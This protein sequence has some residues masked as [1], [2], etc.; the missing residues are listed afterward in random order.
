M[1]DPREI[2]MDITQWV[3]SVFFFIFSYG[4]IYF[5]VFWNWYNNRRSP[6]ILFFFNNFQNKRLDFQF[7]TNSRSSYLLFIRWPTPPFRPWVLNWSPFLFCIH[8]YSIVDEINRNNIISV[9]VRWW[10]PLRKCF[11]LQCFFCWKDKF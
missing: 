1:A 9:N 6:L 3:S 5:L 4:F 8:I 10:W 11:F 7:P 2:L